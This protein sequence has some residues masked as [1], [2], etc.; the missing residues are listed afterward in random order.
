MG[1]IQKARAL[2]QQVVAIERDIAFIPEYRENATDA[3][4]L[5][6]ALASYLEW[7]TRIIIAC[8]SALEDAN[9]HAAAEVLKQATDVYAEI[10]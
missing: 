8:I 2:L 5:G 10:L 4:C 6:L 9:F 3:E 1:D 7:D